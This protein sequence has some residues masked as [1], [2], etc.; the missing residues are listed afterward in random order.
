MKKKL[1]EIL[2]ASAISFSVCTGSEIG[3]LVTK[4][5]KPTI[6]DPKPI[7]SKE[8][9]GIYRGVSGETGAPYI[10]R[11]ILLNNNIIYYY[12]PIK[13]LPKVYPSLKQN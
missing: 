4:I 2:W 12:G 11:C 6:P 1:T 10:Q 9:Y 5:E 7:I 8:C 13:L 3:K